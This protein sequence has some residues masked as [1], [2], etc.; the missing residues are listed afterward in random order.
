[1]DAAL[2]NPSKYIQAIAMKGRDVTVTI[3]AVV[4]REMEREDGTKEM[5]GMIDM[6]G[7]DKSWVVNV[8]NRKCLVAMFGAETDAWIGKRVTLYPEP[9]KKSDSGFAIRVRGS[10]DIQNDIPFVL[11][12]ARKKPRKILLKAT[13]KTANGNGHG[14]AN[15]TAPASNGK[16]APDP[17]PPQ[18]PE[19][20]PD[21]A[22]EDPPLFNDEDPPDGGAAHT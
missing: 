1:M 20:P 16:P 7:T 19:E 10:P 17:T 2:L 4:L 15:G 3:T 9:N 8:T 22:P 11:K 14:T 21:G 13:S 18:D 12:L 5:Q 6:K